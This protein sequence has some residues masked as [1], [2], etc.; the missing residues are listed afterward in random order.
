MSI[1]RDNVTLLGMPDCVYNKSESD[2]VKITVTRDSAAVE[3]S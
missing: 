2:C 3:L 1:S